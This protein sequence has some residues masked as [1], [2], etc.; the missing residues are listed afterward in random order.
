MHVGKGSCYIYIAL[1]SCIARLNQNSYVNNFFINLLKINE[2]FTIKL[3]NEY[4]YVRLRCHNIYI[5]I[6]IYIYI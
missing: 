2:Y 4:G 3:H 6:Y 1:C 5:N